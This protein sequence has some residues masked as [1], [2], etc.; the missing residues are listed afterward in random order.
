MY[1]Q[2]KA[3]GMNI[4][5]GDLGQFMRPLNAKPR[6]WF[7]AII[8]DFWVGWEEIVMEELLP[9]MKLVVVCSTDWTGEENK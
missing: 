6:N 2:T 3:E 8:E 1:L 5:E 4:R 9:E 7:Y